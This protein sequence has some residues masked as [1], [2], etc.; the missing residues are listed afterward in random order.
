MKNINKLTILFFFSLFLISIV[1]F[2]QNGFPLP[3]EEGDTGSDIDVPIF[4][5]VILYLFLS[6][7]SLL[8]IKK[9]KNRK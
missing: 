3:G 1:T 5:N 7:G 2:A 9:I 6:I 8:G 4:G